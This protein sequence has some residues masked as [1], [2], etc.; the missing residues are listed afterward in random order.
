MAGPFH[1]FRVQARS[2]LTYRESIA[3]Y[4]PYLIGG[5]G[6]EVSLHTDNYVG[7]KF[8]LSRLLSSISTGYVHHGTS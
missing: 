7:L 3:Q 5:P 8:E 6:D 4:H 1:W 2:I